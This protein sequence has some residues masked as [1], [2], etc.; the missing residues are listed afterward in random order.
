VTP[1]RAWRWLT[2]VTVALAGCAVPVDDHATELRAEQLPPALAATTAPVT[3]EPSSEATAGA[4]TTQPET[5]PFRIWFIAGDQLQAVTRL[6]S[7]RATTEK[8]A[9]EL[10]AGPSREEIDRFG[11]RSA[12]PDGAITSTE[13]RGGVALVD[14]DPSFV[15]IPT[16]DQILAVGQLVLTF[17]GLP[18]VGQVRFAV[19]G[20]TVQVPRA[21]GSQADGPVARDDYLPLRQSA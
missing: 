20:A 6:V 12:V 16:G 4:S 2:V 15:S 8:L 18:G 17:T 11:L 14:L 21:D 9:A 7:E 10:L 3:T 1:S 5:T 13:V 19:D